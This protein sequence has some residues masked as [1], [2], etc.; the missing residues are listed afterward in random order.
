MDIFWIALADDGYIL[1]VGGV[2]WM[3][4][5]LVVSGGGCG[6]YILAGGGWGWVVGGG[7]G[8]CWIVLGRGMWWHGLVSSI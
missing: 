1:A 2:W 5:W 8:W 3:V 7:S 4:I 6:G